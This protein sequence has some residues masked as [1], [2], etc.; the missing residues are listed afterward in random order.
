MFDEVN[1]RRLPEIF[2]E[3]RRFINQLLIMREG[4]FREP[5]DVRL[6]LGQF[7]GFG[8]RQTLHG[9]DG[10]SE[11]LQISLRDDG[12]GIFQRNDFS[13]FGDAQTS[14]VRGV[15]LRAASSRQP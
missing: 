6:P 5:V 3:L 11:L 1:R 12:I 2:R 14:A 8:F 9:D 7:R 15:R 4:K 13:L 10:G